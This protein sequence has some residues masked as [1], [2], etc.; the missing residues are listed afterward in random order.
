MTEIFDNIRK[1]YRFYVPTNELAEF[2]E[3]FSESSAAETYR[4]VADNRFSVKMFPSWTPTCYINLG[5][6]YQL[7]IGARQYLIQKDTDVLILR[8]S[9]VERHNLPT[10]YIFTIK[11]FPGGL[12]AVLGINQVRFVDQAVNLATIL[13]IDILQHV[14]Q[15]DT[16]EERVDLLQRYFLSRF[17]QSKKTDHYRQFVATTI[18]T[19][20]ASGMV[21]NTGQLADRL[22]ATSKTINRYFH[23]IIG[24]S[25]KNY[26]LTVR[27]RAALSGYVADKNRFSPYDFGYYDMSHFYKDV[28]RFTGKKLRES[29]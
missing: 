8:N 28:V 25:P 15:L 7:S 14:K 3:F 9:I 13:P 10:D 21:L 27:T 2:I 16:F 18:G 11:F 17:H 24:I 19:F 5:E 1:L 22:F 4:Q 23:R 29:H 12:E 6:P 26:L 20:D